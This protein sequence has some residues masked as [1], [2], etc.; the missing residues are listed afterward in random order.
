[1]TLVLILIG[2]GLYLRVALACYRYFVPRWSD[3]GDKDLGLL[4]GLALIWPMSWP[5]FPPW[6]RSLAS[7][8]KK[9]HA[10]GE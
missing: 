9:R 10:E 6:L 3:E 8:K 5:T 7:P 1:M 2:V 4:A